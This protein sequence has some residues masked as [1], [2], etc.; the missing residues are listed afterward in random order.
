MRTGF[1]DGER[2]MFEFR[3]LKT[4]KTTGARAGELTTPHGIVETP[5]FM[6]V[7]T[8]ATVK[9]MSV[10]EL[11]EIETQILLGNTYHLYLRPGPELIAEAGGL[12]RFMGW[13]R[14]ILTDSGGFQ[15]FS[16][17]QLQKITDEGVFCRSHIDGS[18]HVMSPEWAMRVQEMLGSDIA[19]CFDQCTVYPA[20]RD[21]AKAALDRT[22][23]WAKRSQRAH[24]RSDQ[25][26]FGIVQGSVYDDLRLR[27]A[28]EL[29]DLD[30]VGYGIGGLSV[31]EPHED[32][33]RI[34]D[35]LHPVMPENKPRYLMG[36]GYPPNI[37]EGVARGVDMFDCVLPTRNGRN[38][39]LFTSFGRVNIKARKYERDFSSP[40]PE[41]DCYLCRNFSRAY[42]RHLYRAGEILAARLCSWHNLRFTIRL[43]Q[44]AREA[45]LA[46][47]YPQFAA[48]FGNTF[49][50]GREDR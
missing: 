17:A 14:P 31:G 23:L 1:S 21:V 27:S 12:H 47:N 25:A 13:D 5:V 38:G 44:R 43:A 8:Q 35:L 49:A 39:T 22:T 18:A 11:L 4:C 15:V 37:V 2:F 20:S 48:D 19:M 45:I 16:L 6:P 7:G 10:R 24:S 9:A 41:C 42:L 29:I 40:D 30:F 28:R 46:G 34:L 36:V 32:M 26:L 3:I 50:D 33:Y